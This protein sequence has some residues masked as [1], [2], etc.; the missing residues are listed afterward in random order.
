MLQVDLVLFRLK[1]CSFLRNPSLRKKLQND[2]GIDRIVQRESL[3]SSVPL[4]NNSESESEYS[5][6]SE[7]DAFD[8]QDHVNPD[9]HLQ[10]L[11]ASWVSR[12]N[13]TTNAVRELLEILRPAHPSLPKDPRTLLKT[14]INYEVQQI[15]GGSY[16]HFGV[17]KGVKSQL[18]LF[19]HQT[20]LGCENILLQINIDGL[21]LFKNSGT[22]FWPLLGR[23][24]SP[25]VTQPFIIGLFS[26]DKKPDH[27]GSYLEQFV[28]EMT[29]LQE[30][31]IT[32]DETG[33]LFT[34][35]I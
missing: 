19:E 16:F 15:A 29:F 3:D 26:G 30:N 34:I 32:D 11:L 8:D 28:S 22:Q 9:D 31:G 10:Y 35:S 18:G 23:I 24:I 21:P 2:T 7:T 17:A 4:E 27:V 33:M 6:E 5:H 12:N 25:V 1:S 20:F 13:I 14:N